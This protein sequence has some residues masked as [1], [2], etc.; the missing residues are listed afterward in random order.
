MKAIL[1]LGLL[2][3]FVLSG[4]SVQSTTG[5]VVAESKVKEFKVDA[6]RWGYTPDIIKVKKGDQVKISINNTDTPHGMRI[7]GL[8]LQGE[9]AI[10]FTADA[11]GTYV[12]YCLIPCGQGHMQMSGKII[13]D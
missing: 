1:A 9:K 11:S 3:M 6:Y 7:P 5:K 2:I 4:C 10:E 8:N 12:W 13:I